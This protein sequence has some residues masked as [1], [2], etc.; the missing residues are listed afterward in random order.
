MG[1][2]DDDDPFAPVR[3][4]PEHVLGQSLDDLSIEELKLRIE[5]LKAEIVRLEDAQRA[6]AASQASA[7]AFFKPSP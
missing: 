5:A 1:R 7:A 4:Q 3:K 6:K 2:H